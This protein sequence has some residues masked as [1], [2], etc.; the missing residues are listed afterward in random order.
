MFLRNF[1]AWISGGKE[2]NN[3]GDATGTSLTPYERGR[4]TR[5]RNQ[6]KMK[7]MSEGMDLLKKVYDYFLDT[8]D[9][10]NL[11]PKTVLSFITKAF[12]KASKGLRE[13]LDIPDIPR[14]SPR[15]NYQPPKEIL[16]EPKPP[17]EIKK[18]KH[19][20][21]VET[22][23]GPTLSRPPPPPPRPE[24]P[25]PPIDTEVVTEATAS[26]F[27]KAQNLLARLYGGGGVGR[28]PPISDGAPQGAYIR[29]PDGKFIT[30][31]K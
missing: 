15:L 25:I 4:L 11:D 16:D 17:A 19:D 26:N 5:E 20:D 31:K 27:Q 3:D 2:K 7:I 10:D 6:N 13:E 9:D 12:G 28:I 14:R 24:P 21:V 18:R 22:A 8:D 23:P 1:P 30:I 29:G